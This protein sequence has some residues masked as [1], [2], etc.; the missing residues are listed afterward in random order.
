MDK[1]KL[2]YLRDNYFSKSRDQNVSAVFT[3]NEGVS[4]NSGVFAEKATVKENTYIINMDKF[5]SSVI[6]NNTVQLF[7][8]IVYIENCYTGGT[9]GGI[10]FSIPHMQVVPR[11]NRYM[12]VEL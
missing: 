10:G 7:E 3:V 9:Y 12:P 5:L 6:L 4:F 11:R 1:I 2:D 8:D